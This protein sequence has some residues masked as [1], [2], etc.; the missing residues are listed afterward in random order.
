[1]R[2][3]FRAVRTMPAGVLQSA[4]DRMCGWRRTPLSRTTPCDAR[5]TAGPHAWSTRSPAAWGRQPMSSA[6]GMHAAPTAQK[7]RGRCASATSWRA[8]AAASH[9]A[10]NT[11]SAARREASGCARLTKRS[12]QLMAFVHCSV[13]AA[14]CY[15]CGRSTCLTCT[16]TSL[17]AGV[18]ACDACLIAATDGSP[19]RA[20]A[21][22]DDGSD[23]R[24]EPARGPQR[25]HRHAHLDLARCGAK[26]SHSMQVAESSAADVWIPAWRERTSTPGSARLASEPPSVA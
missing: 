1:M 5:S 15:I 8:T 13:H 20:G 26:C 4:C 17:G 19:R 24:K 2:D 12:A 18:A 22:S 21:A 6:I 16:T 9:C 7:T 11:A 14:S 10:R 23:V 25:R 3:A